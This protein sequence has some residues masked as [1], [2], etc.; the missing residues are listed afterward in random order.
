APGVVIDAAWAGT[1]VVVL[2]EDGEVF[3][4]ERPGPTWVRVG[5]GMSALVGSDPVYAVGATASTGLARLGDELEPI[6]GAP[7]GPTVEWGGAPAVY[8]WS[9]DTV[10]IL[11]ADGWTPVRLWV[12]EGFTAEFVRLVDGAAQPTVV[13]RGARGL[14]L[15]TR[16]R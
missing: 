10:R 16:A 3:A 1:G 7:L 5:G 13:A 15:W 4:T 2:T 14:A 8:D 11:T 12:S 6:P 9:T